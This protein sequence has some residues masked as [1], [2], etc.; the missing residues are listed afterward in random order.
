MSKI[1]FFPLK[2]MTTTGPPVTQFSVY[3]SFLS[4][5]F[6]TCV[7]MWVQDMYGSSPSFGAINE[8]TEYFIAHYCCRTH[9]L[10]QVW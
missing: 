5:L 6:V 1:S 4:Q 8:E 2:K 9:S 7:Y 3:T 10:R